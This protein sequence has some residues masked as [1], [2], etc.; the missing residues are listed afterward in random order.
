MINFLFL[1]A[2]LVLAILVIFPF[3]YLTRENSA[4]RP[5]ISHQILPPGYRRYT[6][7]VPPDYSDEKPTPLILVLHFAGHG[8]PFYGEMILQS[9]IEPA[10]RELKPIIIAPDCPVKDWT[11]PESEQLIFDLLD[12]IQAQFNIDAGRIFSPGIPSVVWAPGILLGITLTV[13]PRL[14]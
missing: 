10:F 6:V 3:F 1:I 9:M 2:L 8:I 11:Q 4:I 7:S 13:L 5:G 12:K 14:L